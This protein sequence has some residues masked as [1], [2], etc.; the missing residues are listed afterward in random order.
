MDVGKAAVTVMGISKSFGS[1]V[2]LQN[3]NFSVDED[4]MEFTV[5][6]PAESDPG[7]GRISSA[8]PV[9]RALMGRA[10]GDDAIVTTP[11]GDVRYR[12]VAIT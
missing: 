8:S 10:A 1:T 2:V 9:G 7:S 5:V 11:R 12:V 3:I 6:G 4:E